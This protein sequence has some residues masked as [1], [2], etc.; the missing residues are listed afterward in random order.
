M[1]RRSSWFF[2]HELIPEESVQEVRDDVDILV[3]WGVST[4]GTDSL[5]K[6]AMVSLLSGSL[7]SESSASPLPDSLGG[8]MGDVVSG[9][10][11]IVDG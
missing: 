7:L 10:Q 8:R 9:C 1:S 2:G 11:S 3:E 5:T 4:E 6:S